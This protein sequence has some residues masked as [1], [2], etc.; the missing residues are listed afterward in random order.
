[1]ARSCLAEL[2]RLPLSG[3]SLAGL[4]REQ[5]DVV[6]RRTERGFKTVRVSMRLCE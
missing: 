3:R 2:E 1:M 6:D 5:F 4:D